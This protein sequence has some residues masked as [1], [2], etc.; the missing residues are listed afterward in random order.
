MSR[1][2]KSRFSLFLA[3]ASFC[4]AQTAVDL[5]SEPV[6]R[7][8]RKLACNCGCAQDMT[9]Q[10]E[11]GCGTCK[12][13]KMKIF[14]EQQAGK[15]DQQILDEFVAE[16]GKTIL[17]VTPGMFGTAGPFVA[18]SLGGIVVLF[19]IRRYMKKPHPTAAGPE[20]DPEVLDKINKDMAKLD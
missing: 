8:A 9:C 5:V 3:L 1:F 12:R 4:L 16:N 15:S 10:M 6:N 20:I 17:N 11:P 14:A 13:A 19:V 18:L 2:N 7:V